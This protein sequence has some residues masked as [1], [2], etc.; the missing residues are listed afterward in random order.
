MDHV[1]NVEIVLGVG[2]HRLGGFDCGGMVGRVHDEHWTAQKRSVARRTKRVG[3]F[4]ERR[5]PP[6][7]TKYAYSTF[8]NANPCSVVYGI[9]Q[10]LKT[11]NYF[12]KRF[13]IPSAS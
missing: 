7:T 11:K 10:R 3:L 12:D 9:V 8:Y 1:R 6:A 2:G 4:Q 5:C 13:C